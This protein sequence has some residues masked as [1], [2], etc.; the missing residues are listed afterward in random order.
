M[1]R[2][3]LGVAPAEFGLLPDAQGWLSV[4]E[5]V[6]ALHDEDG[7]RHLRQGMV[8]DAAIRLASDLFEL[9]DK[10]IRCL[11]RSYP[12]PDHNASPPAHLYLGLRRRAWPVAQKRGLEAGP[13]GRPLLLAVNP[14]IALKL[15]RRR[16]AEPVL[17]TVQALQATEQ[18]AV[19]AGW[20]ELFL[21]AWAP[22]ACLMGPPMEERP[23]AKKPP[24]KK[25]EPAPSLPP[26]QALPGSFTVTAEDL[27]KPYKRKGLK[28]QIKWKDQRRQDRRRRGG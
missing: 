11:S 9:Q 21:C 25:T 5:L 14:E 8:A 7:W 10:R 28:K 26:P 3:A 23:R 15:G 19:F 22:A 12:P 6:R 17:V 4:K 13:D 2:Y 20:G 27:E 24:A 16:D 18:G 1:L